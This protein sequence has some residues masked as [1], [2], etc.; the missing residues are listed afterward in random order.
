MSRP[1]GFQVKPFEPTNQSSPVTSSNTTQIASDSS[2]AISLTAAVT[3]KA[4]RQ[5][6]IQGMREGS[7][8]G[9]AETPLD[10][11]VASFHF[12]GRGTHAVGE[13]P[14]CHCPEVMKKSRSFFAEHGCAAQSRRCAASTQVAIT[15]SAGSAN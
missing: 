13:L 8:H 15:W 12:I 9:S 10:Q 1:C 2:S 6:N 11:I 14:R 5:Q 4:A 3:G 7:T